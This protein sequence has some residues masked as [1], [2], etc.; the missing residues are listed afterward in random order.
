[1]EG[2]VS[3]LIW[4][5]RTVCQA[6]VFSHHDHDKGMNEIG[7]LSYYIILSFVLIRFKSGQAEKLT[8][9]AI[10]KCHLRFF[11]KDH[12]LH[13]SV[14]STNGCHRWQPLVWDIGYWWHVPMTA[15]GEHQRWQPLIARKDQAFVNRTKIYT[16][17]RHF[18]KVFFGRKIERGEEKEM[19]DRK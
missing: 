6:C 8:F 14:A 17:F 12:R 9:S 16:D 2:C 15:M 1:M 18:Q 7:L 3:S 11:Q 13:L 10:W 4:I 19:K 5:R